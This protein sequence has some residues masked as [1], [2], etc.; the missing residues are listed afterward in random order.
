MTDE[1]YT[2]HDVKCPK[3]MNEFQLKRPALSP[4]E[5]LFVDV[6]RAASRKIDIQCPHCGHTFKS[7]ERMPDFEIRKNSAPF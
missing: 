1:T 5:S 2:L 4:M 6:F 7:K 3:C